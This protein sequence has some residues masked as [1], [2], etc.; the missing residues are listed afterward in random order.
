MRSSDP[1]VGGVG[2]TPT[3]HVVA[4]AAPDTAALLRLQ[5]RER[6]RIGFDLHDGP[7]QTMSAALLQVKM[8]E[9]MEGEDRTNG[10]L[11]LRSTIAAALEEVYE[12]IERLGGRD[13]P[14][15]DL[16]SRVRSCVESFR[17]RGDA[18]ARLAVE[19]EAG[20]VSPSLRIAVFRIVQEALSNVSRHSCAN[21]VDVRLALAS[22]EVVCE[23]TDDGKG[24]APLDAGTSWRGREP[25]GLHSMRERARLLDGE[26]TIDSAPGCGT[27]VRVRIPVWRG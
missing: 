15:D 10:L 4:L 20:S 6:A 2:A 23:V 1:S 7:A 19:G 16:V 17:V 12:L 22:D 24:F 18:E 3:R 21:R 25:Y 26:C 5:E 8:L 11:E 13:V 9:D 14:E 27:R